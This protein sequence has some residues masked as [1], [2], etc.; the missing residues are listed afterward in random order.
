M[1]SQ[2]SLSLG[3][4]T[5]KSYQQYGGGASSTITAS[6]R[7]S[8]LDVDN[9]DF[10]LDVSSPTS[11]AGEHPK[12]RCRHQVRIRLKQTSSADD[13]S[14]NKTSTSAY[15]KL[16]SSPCKHL[17]PYKPCSKTISPW[18]I[19]VICGPF[20]ARNGGCSARSTLFII[21]VGTQ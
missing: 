15:L 14:G 16:T 6:T 20:H 18:Q 13:I 19:D 9:D 5:E 21:L 1:T 12:N 3:T 17:R 2:E 8:A 10:K 7:P 4:T 11:S